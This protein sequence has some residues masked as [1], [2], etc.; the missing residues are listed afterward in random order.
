[1]DVRETEFFK[2]IC[3]EIIGEGAYRQ[4]YECRLNKDWVVKVEDE[5]DDGNF[6]NVNEW[7]TWTTKKHE[8][9]VAGW[10]APCHQISHG[11]RFLIQSRT[12]PVAKKDLP[13]KIPAF[14]TD[15][16]AENFGRLD[17]RVVCH[18]YGFIS[19]YMKTRLIKA[20]WNE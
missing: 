2:L 18:D 13:V 10:L 19:T 3:G 4:V 8:L 6:C 14:L 7:K 16:K 15:V 5:D 20:H 12:R 17:D 9:A 11:G 1:M